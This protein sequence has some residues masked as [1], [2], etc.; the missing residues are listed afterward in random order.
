MESSMRTPSP[1]R[2]CTRAKIC[3]ASARVKFRF[4]PSRLYRECL[5]SDLG[6]RRH[7][8][9]S[10]SAD[11]FRVKGF[12]FR[13]R[14]G[15]RPV[16][17]VRLASLDVRQR[18]KLDYH[19]R[20]QQRCGPDPCVGNR[21]YQAN[22]KS[23]TPSNTSAERLI[24]PGALAGKHPGP[25]LGD[26]HA[27][28]QAD[29]E[30]AIDG[31]HR[32]V[33]EAHSGTQERPVASDQVGPLVAV[34]ADAVAG[35]VRQARHFVTWTEAGIDNDFARRGVHGFAGCAWFGG[36]E[37][38]ILGPTL[39]VP[40]LDL[41][42][43][44]LSKYDG[45]RDV[46]LISL[47]GAAIVDLDDVAWAQFLGL[48]AAMGEGGVLAEVHRHLPGDAESAIG[49]PNVV[50]QRGRRHAFVERSEASPVGGD[51]DVV[52]PL[53]QSDLRGGFD[54]AAAGRHWTGAHQLG[55]RGLFTNPVE[56][57]KADLFF[58]S[59]AS[60]D[61]SA[62]FEDLR[63]PPEGTLI[64]LPSANVGVEANHLPRSG[65]F[66]RGDYPGEIAPRRE[67]GAEGPFASAPPDSGEI[68]QTGTAFEEDAPDFVFHHQAPGFVHALATFAIGY[69]LDAV[70][71][72]TK[73]GDGVRGRL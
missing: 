9:G 33:A 8:A 71:H 1:T 73:L 22:P 25:V 15:H 35:A 50:G 21:P 3:C 13:R 32:F 38:S 72:R 18:R 11:A 14:F 36:G 70:R 24:D 60:A 26:V 51:G 68:E 27:I 30:L 2:I 59:H 46:G 37:S 55:R 12:E 31:D 41:A 58:D 49:A 62:I 47:D 66:E 54:H 7:D 6:D 48:N 34:Q 42:R 52:A 19:Q 57:E 16:S 10:E 4:E 67:Y 69:R 29:S 17:S 56:N 39:E 40:Y 44:R 5:G 20:R 61:D 64:L 23:G 65:F 43:R 63:D 28:F 53:Q 45:S